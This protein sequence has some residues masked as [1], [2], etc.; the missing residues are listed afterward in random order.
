MNNNDITNLMNMIGKMD[1]NQL[2]NSLNQLNGMLSNEDK[3]KIMQA[4]NSMK[5]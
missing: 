3:K 4:L 5:K 2:A 1:K